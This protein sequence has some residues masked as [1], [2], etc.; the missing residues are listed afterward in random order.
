[1]PIGRREVKPVKPNLWIAWLVAL[2]IPAMIVV[3]AIVQA[4]ESGGS[5]FWL[6]APVLLTGWMGAL[7]IVRLP[8]NR[9]GW[10]LALGGMAGG[11]SGLAAA[12]IPST[13]IP[14]VALPEL[15]PFQVVFGAGMGAVGWYTLLFVW[16]IGVPLLFPTGTPPSRRWRW[17]GW[18]GGL[19]IAA[20]ILLSLFAQEQCDT[21]ALIDASAESGFRGMQAC[22]DNPLGIA[23]LPDGE[24]GIVGAAG[25]AAFL[26]ALVGALISLVV[27]IRRA[28]PVERHQIKWVLFSFSLI[29]IALAATSVVEGI[30]GEDAL[31]GYDW[32][33]IVVFSLFPI[34]IATSILRY[35]LYEIDR[36]ISRTVTYFL[37]V[38]MLASLFVVVVSGALLVVPAQNSLAVA[39]STLVVAALFNPLR[40]RIQRRVDR[41]FNRSRYNAQNVVD[42]FAGSLQDRVTSENVVDGWVTVVSSTM[43]PSAL[44]VWMRDQATRR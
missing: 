9:I 4:A 28:G 22:F 38:G 7:L 37:V 30:W 44:G 15:S 25:T 34:S 23:G 43:E 17:V 39:A 31:S 3:A 41:R 1:M 32:T 36:I 8:S 19:S 11:L 2:S 42:A 29:V 26:A 35:R 40:R 14:S 21:W 5:N 6:S 33:S 13:E 20:V 12:T 18:L 10:L 16:L 24:S 27:R